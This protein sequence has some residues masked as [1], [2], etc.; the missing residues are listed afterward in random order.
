ME[1]FGPGFRY[2]YALMYFSIHILLYPIFKSPEYLQIIPRRKQP[3]HLVQSR[4]EP[5]CIHKNRA[6]YK[7]SND[8]KWYDAAEDLRPAAY[9]A[10][11]PG[12]PYD[13]AA[14]TG[15][16]RGLSWQGCHHAS[17]PQGQQA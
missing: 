14:V 9:Q 17:R 7:A 8:Q 10:Q 5:P 3:A 12:R 6:E 4:K 11:N 1:D 16:N 13:N 15:H 2:A